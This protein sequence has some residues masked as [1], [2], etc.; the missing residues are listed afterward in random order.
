M[1]DRPANCA[2][3]D[4]AP[5]EAP[6]RVRV[7]LPLPLP[8]ALD[9]RVPGGEAAPQPGCFVRVSL[10]PRR[11]I[12][13]VWDGES[14]AEEVPDERLKPIAEVLPAPPLPAELRRFIDRVAS[15]TLA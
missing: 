5:S 12:G 9:Y 8:A 1:A 3:L 11:L 15:Y 6:G 7:L 10:G 13:V 2:G 4:A 14:E